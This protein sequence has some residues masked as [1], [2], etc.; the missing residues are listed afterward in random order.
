MP[1]T[2]APQILPRNA[3][4]GTV[5]SIV[6]G[7]RPRRRTPA[8]GG[9]PFRSAGEERNPVLVQVVQARCVVPP[10]TR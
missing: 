3:W 2:A 1:R 9:S 7:A 6:G 5:Q 8:F 4:E 10:L